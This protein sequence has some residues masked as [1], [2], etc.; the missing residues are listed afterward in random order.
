MENKILG[1]LVLY[2]CLLKESRT[3]RTVKKRSKDLLVFDNSEQSQ[4]IK[5]VAPDV[6]YIHNETNVGLSACYN[7]AA[8]FARE[9]GYQWLLFLDQDTD[10]SG[11]TIGDYEKAI[12]ENPDCQM[13]AP[14]VKCGEYT[15]SPMNFKHHFATLSK[16]SFLGKQKINDI[17]VINSGMC[18]SLEAFEKCGGY[19]EK[20]FL[21]YS[22]HEF[23]GRYKKH[24]EFLYVLPKV[25]RQ[26]FSAKTDSKQSSLG[27]FRL[28]CRSLSG[29]EKE[30]FKDVCE[31]AFV[32][33]K[34]MLSLMLRFH[35]I[36]PCGIAYKN[37]F[38]K[39]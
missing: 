25:I 4:N 30:G 39:R 6:S 20:V 23:V 2:N 33:T 21:D 7:Q 24:F 12:E 34:R 10:F 17:S 31:Y 35:T 19:N 13:I 28:F 38:F 15:M 1:V 22:D 32:I 9:H 27:R 14:M 36:A 16:V 26:D 8:K 37:Y 11:V 18:V 29:C 5:S 3:Y